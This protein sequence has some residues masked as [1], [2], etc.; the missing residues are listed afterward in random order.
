M[1]LME[2]PLRPVMVCRTS[3]RR[4]GEMGKVG[5]KDF[6]LT[7]SCRDKRIAGKQPFSIALLCNLMAIWAF[8]VNPEIGFVS[9]VHKTVIYASKQPFQ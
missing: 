8:K 6:D 7:L 1:R 9:R 4:C 2:N 3:S 5:V